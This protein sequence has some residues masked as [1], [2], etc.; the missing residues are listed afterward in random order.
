[1]NI[2]ETNEE[3]ATMLRA[4]G[5]EV[6]TYVCD[7]SKR[8]DVCRVAEKVKVDVGDVDILVNNAGILSGKQLMKL[9]DAEIQRTMDI[10]IMAHFWVSNIN[11]KS[12]AGVQCI[13]IT[14]IFVFARF[15]PHCHN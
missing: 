6:H 9:K 11:G 1:M 7:C 5:K 13:I 3:T 2:A 12:K 15:N 10:N 14:L 4:L 8:E